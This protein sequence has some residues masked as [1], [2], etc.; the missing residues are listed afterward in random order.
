M[1]T[2][3]SHTINSSSAGHLT[4]LTGL[5]GI[6]AYSVLMAHAFNSSFAYNAVCPFEP[7]LIRLAYFGM[8][9]FFVLSGFVIHYNYTKAFQSRGWIW[10]S[11]YFITARFARLYPLY[12]LAIFFSLHHLPEPALE[13]NPAISVA[14]V[15][16]TQS[17]FDLQE[18]IFPPAWS[19]STEWFFYLFFI[20]FVKFLDRIYRPRLILVV[21]LMIVPML[22][23][24]I[25]R[26]QDLIL[27]TLS[28]L[29]NDPFIRAKEG[30]WLYYYAPYIR[31]FEFIA[32]IL[33]SK[34]YLSL[35]SS[36][37]TKERN[38]VLSFLV[39]LCCIG[40]CMKVILTGRTPFSHVITFRDVISAKDMVNLLPNFLFA[41]A[42]VPF[43]V[44]VCRYN[45]SVS[46][47]LSSRPLLFMGEISYSVYILQFWMITSLAAFYI[48]T[49]ISMNA[50]LN[51]LIKSIGVIGLTTMIAFGSYHLIERPCRKW[52]KSFFDLPTTN[53]AAEMKT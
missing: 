10:G 39:C 15:T 36:T 17:W 13:N 11:Y 18:I 42:I 30:R 7:Y 48:S 8:S 41:P 12:A 27:N 49:E 44:L 5:R 31:I 45:T 43:L 38:S 2:I 32:G 50:Y 21:F 22:L 14:Y 37:C 35:T 24:A 6:A 20:I 52:I 46:R 4:P 51:S 3:E 26:S 1:H 23:M 34:V 33:S 53:L 40:W 28:T 19:I 25:F 9:L 16:M 47:M 29:W